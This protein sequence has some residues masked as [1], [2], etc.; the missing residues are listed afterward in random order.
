MRAETPYQNDD[1]FA[2][3]ASRI[4]IPKTSPVSLEAD[5]ASHGVSLVLGYQDIFGAPA[6]IEGITKRLQ[7]HSLEFVI[8]TVARASAVLNYSATHDDSAA[9]QSMLI[10]RLFAKTHLEVKASVDRLVAQQ[11]TQFALFHERQLL[12][13]AKIAFLTMPVAEMQAHEAADDAIGEAL[14][15]VGELIDRGVD[16]D[17]EG[18]EFRKKLELYAF[19]N[20]LFNQR[21]NVV[22]GLARG[23]DFYLQRNPRVYNPASDPDLPALIK[24]QTGVEPDLLWAILFLFFGYYFGLSPVEIDQGKHVLSYQKFLRISGIAEDE[25]NRLFAL[26]TVE[27]TEMQSAVKEAFGL[28]D[29]RFYDVLP[30]AVYPMVRFADRVYCLSVPLLRNA[31]GPGLQYRFLDRKT[32]THQGTERFLDYRGRVFEDHVSQVLSRIFGQRHISEAEILARAG[33][34][35]SCDHLVTYGHAVVLFECKAAIVPHGA[36]IGMD[37]DNY[38]VFLRRAFVRAADQLLETILAIK[39]G[40]F[41][42]LGLDAGVIETY[43]PMVATFELPLNQLTYQVLFT[44]RLLSHPIL[45][46]K[47]TAPIQAIDIDELEMLEVAAG[48]GR[49]LLDLLITKVSK[50]EF[51][52]TSFNNVWFLAGESFAGQHNPH[53]QQRYHELTDHSV[54]ILRARGLPKGT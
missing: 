44:Q 15:M 47:S 49:S 38:D 43:Y 11:G 53:W 28:S 21:P 23:H 24:E 52:G 26:T 45:S 34:R 51:V 54:N 8:S 42:D 48:A 10:R 29:L 25:S 36:R 40:A 41:R 6:S 22:N 20:T 46:E 9:G 31:A 5:P 39:N 7:H 14:L 16:Q 30:F 1:S 17:E 13:L 12:N 3:T 2:R 18:A 19:A 4:W 33:G 32:F 35:P 50:N 27:A 37:W